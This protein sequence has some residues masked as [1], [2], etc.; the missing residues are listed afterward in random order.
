MSNNKIRLIFV[1]HS[2]TESEKSGVVLGIRD[3]CLETDKNDDA[4]SVAHNLEN[5][6]WTFDYVWTSPLIRSFQMAKDVLNHLNIQRFHISVSPELMERDFGAFTGLTREESVALYGDKAWDDAFE[7]WEHQVVGGESMEDVARRL[8][9]WL[10][11]LEKGEHPV[12]HLIFTHPHVIRVA[13]VL[14]GLREKNEEFSEFYGYGQVLAWSG[15][16]DAN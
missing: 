10:A 3:D 8:M 13:T 11:T 5:E 4:I 15:T 9:S 12:T 7:H 1:G 6:D 2:Q 16:V 14:L